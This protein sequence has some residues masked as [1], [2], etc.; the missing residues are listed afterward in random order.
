VPTAAILGAAG[1]TGQET[2]DRI[3]RHPELELVALGSDS[4]AGR[5]AHVL[6]PGLDGN[7]PMFSPNVEAAASGAD[8]IFLCLGNEQAAAYEPPDDDTIV[9]DLGGVHRLADNALAER[10][11]GV[12]PGA[13][14][15]GLPELHPAEGPLIANPGC[16][17]TATLL[18]L[19]PLREVL[20]GDVVVDAKSG[21]TGAGRRLQDRMHAG[22]VLENFAPYAVGAHRHAPEIEQLLGS[23]ICFVPH[24]LPVRRGLLATCYLRTDTDVRA[25]LEEAYAES[26]VVRVLPAGVEPE[27]ARVQGTDGAEL[28]VFEDGSTGMTIVICAEDNLGK[29]AAGQAIQNANLALGLPDTAGL[30]LGSVLV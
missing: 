28:G 5:P 6:H 21:M 9:I 23:P 18:A 24:L 22:A 14:S 15:Y 1:Y 26:A 2:L 20:T 8:V 13:W 19:C 11:Y 3:L 17:A 25:L 10:W 4:L 29:G 7:V 16:Y 12:T 27:I 30:R